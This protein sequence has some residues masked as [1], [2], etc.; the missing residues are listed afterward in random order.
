MASRLT[1]AFTVVV[2]TAVAVLGGLTWRT[3]QRE[4]AALIR[5]RHAATERN[6][7]TLLADAYASSSSWRSA[8]LDPARVV[9][10][11]GGAALS[12]FDVGGRGDKSWYGNERASAN[13]V[14]WRQQ[15]ER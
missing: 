9:A 14:K 4:L 5:T 6:V 13:K 11:T 10:R 1:I 12:V 7:A 2:L 15:P 8:D 3:T